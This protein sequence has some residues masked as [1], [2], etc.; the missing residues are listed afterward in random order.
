MSEIREK[1]RET[2]IRH[3]GSDPDK[4]EYPEEVENLNGLLDTHTKILLESFH[5]SEK[6][7]EEERELIRLCKKHRH[8]LGASR[9]DM[10]EL[11]N[12][13]DKLTG[14]SNERSSN[15]TS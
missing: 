14:E 11:L 13:I 8:S 12:V 2:L 7:T 1:N 10:N 9:Q 5:I 4:A 15:T 3:Y 6:L